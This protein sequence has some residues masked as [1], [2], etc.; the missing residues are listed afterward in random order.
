MPRFKPVTCGWF[1][2]VN[3]S[4]SVA[5]VSARVIL[6]LVHGLVS[7]AWILVSGLVAAKQHEL[8][9]SSLEWSLVL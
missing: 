5:A 3:V 2:P 1:C 7:C 9:L 6:V 8:A 4:E